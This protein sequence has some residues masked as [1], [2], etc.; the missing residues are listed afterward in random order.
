MEMMDYLKGYREDLVVETVVDGQ[1][2]EFFNDREKAH[3]EDVRVLFWGGIRLRRLLLLL[4]VFCT[5]V[6]VCMEEQAARRLS[7]AYLIA[8][9]CFLAAF[10]GIAFYLSRDFTEGF[11]IFH[12]M[13]FDNDLW[14]LDP[15]TDLLIN[16]LPEGFFMDMA[17]HIG[18]V[19][20][21]MLLLTALLSI[22]Y[23][24]VKRIKT[25]KNENIQ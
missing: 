12:H 7:K 9:G 21:G 5:G 14:L 16:I 13:F 3:M 6:L 2:R 11:T 20:G 24:T 22:V 19:F 17:V 15:K 8:C 10:G 1:Q 18:V 25:N 4:A 23:L